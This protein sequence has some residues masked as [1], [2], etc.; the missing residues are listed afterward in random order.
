[1]IQ[2]DRSLKHDLEFKIPS[3]PEFLL[4]I[5][6]VIQ[7]DRSLKHDPEFKIP[8]LPELQIVHGI[9]IM[10]CLHSTYLWFIKI[11][12]ELSRATRQY[13]D[14]FVTTLSSFISVYCRLT[15]YPFTAESIPVSFWYAQAGNIPTNDL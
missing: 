3:L 9:M 2:N 6:Q 1:M 11:L 8:S 10:K 5:F 7:N 13:Y 4:R 14:T 12:S 15:R